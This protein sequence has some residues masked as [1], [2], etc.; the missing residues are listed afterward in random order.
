M[1]FSNFYE[2]KKEKLP[3]LLYE[4]IRY[5][6]SPLFCEDGGDTIQGRT[7]YKGGH[8]LRKYGMYFLCIL[9]SCC[10]HFLIHIIAALFRSVFVSKTP[11]I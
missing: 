10:P 11:D 9:L 4:E 2:F 1:K 5:L 8:Y 6:M 3:Q 7:L